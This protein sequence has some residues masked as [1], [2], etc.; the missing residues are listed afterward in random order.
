MLPVTSM[1]PVEEARERILAYFGRLEPE[2]KPLLDALG[3]VLAEDVVA[4]FD[5]PPLDNTAMDGYAV[6]AADTAGASEAAPVQLRVIADLAAGYVLETPVGPGEAVRIMTGAPVPPGADAIVPF[7]ETDEALRGIN[8]AARKAGSVRVLKAANPGA[9]IR[10]RGEDVQAGS[11]VIPAGRVLRP[12]EIGVLASI[13]LTHVTVIRRPVVAILSTGDEIT[14]PGEPLLPGR[15][16]DANAYSVAALVRKYGGIP[17]ILGIARDTVEDLT[18]KIREGLDADMLV[19][20]AG[21]SRGDFDVV[22]DV[23]AREGNIDFWTVRMRPGKP[24]AFGAFTAPGGRKVPHLGLPGNPVS[25][26]VSFELFGRPAIF[27][28]LGRSDWERPTVRAIS[29]DYVRNPDGRRF[30]ARCIVTRGDD[31][32]WYADLTGPQGSGM[33]TSMSAANALAVIPEDVPAANPGDEIECIML[34]WEHA[35]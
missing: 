11:T 20:S 15:I 9:N 1:I 8:E 29:R 10:R 14:P 21:V 35:P 16:Y 30:Y 3:Q 28:M 24:L 4:P 13:G 23:L 22:K 33:L 32:R 25:S 12:S 6:R 31:G 17:R 18:A 27:T 2:R 19:T 34:D 7:E 26:M 5:I